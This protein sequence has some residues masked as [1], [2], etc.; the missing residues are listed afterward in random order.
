MATSQAFGDEDKA[1]GLSLLD[2][3]LLSKDFVYEK[4]KVSLTE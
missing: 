3:N 4:L 1:E 2:S